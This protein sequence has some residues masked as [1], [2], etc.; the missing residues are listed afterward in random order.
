MITWYLIKP[1]VLT[2]PD[3]K[4]KLV[5]VPQRL[6]K[7]WDTWT[8]VDA[9]GN[10]VEV[11][12]RFRRKYRFPIAV[13][14]DDPAT[15]KGAVPKMALVRV[16]HEGDPPFEPSEVVARLDSQAKWTAA[17]AE[18]PKLKDRFADQPTIIAKG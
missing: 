4:E 10:V 2:S 11:P 9:D 3:G 18:N 14:V 17:I 16:E 6:E 1:V 12:M 8:G 15:T 7:E 13:E 5:T